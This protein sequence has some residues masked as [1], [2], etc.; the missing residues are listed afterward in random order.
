M[1]CDCYMCNMTEEQQQEEND[2]YVEWEYEQYL[3][4]T[5]KPLTI[6]EWF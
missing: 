1:M 6:E 3:K 2:R 4:T 5:D